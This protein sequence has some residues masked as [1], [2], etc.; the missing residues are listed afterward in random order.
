VRRV[1][2]QSGGI[3]VRKPRPHGRGRRLKRSLSWVPGAGLW[4]F[5]G[6][7]RGFA[8]GTPADSEER[9]P[10]WTEGFRGERMPGSIALGKQVQTDSNR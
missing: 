3:P 4:H 5:M 10:C 7:E 9:K 8:P 6:K 1:T 2:R